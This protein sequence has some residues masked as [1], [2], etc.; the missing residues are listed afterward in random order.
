MRVVS[1]GVE[2]T[3]PKPVRAFDLLASGRGVCGWMWY[4]T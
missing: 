3:L 4:D 1:V 2:L